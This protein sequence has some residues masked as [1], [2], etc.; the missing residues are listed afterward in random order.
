MIIE[1]IDDDT[2]KFS[3]VQR[4][5][6]LNGGY[7]M[8]VLLLLVGVLLYCCWLRFRFS[9]AAAFILAVT[10]MV[11]F[12]YMQFRSS[13][14]KEVLLVSGSFGIQH[15]IHFLKGDIQKTF[16]QRERISSFFLHEAFVGWKVLLF[17]A[18][19]LKQ[20]SNLLVPFQN[21]ILSQSE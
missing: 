3:I 20:S 9:F 18:V 6:W 8:V 1:S 13:I 5:H 7:F 14:C 2:C 15:E 17:F 21:L 10:F 11:I 16:V 19:A 12:V 4:K